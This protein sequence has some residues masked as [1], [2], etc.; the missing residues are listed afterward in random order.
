MTVPVTRVAVAAPNEASAQAGVR[1]AAEGGNAVDAALAATL[2]T[3]VNEIGVISPGSGGFVTVQPPGGD[4]VTI[5]G[6]VEMP[7]RGLPPER[8]GKG[9]WDITTE[10]GGGTT[11]TVG[12]GSVA[13]PGALKALDL[14]HERYG[15]APWHEV[16]Q[17]A[18]EVAR[19]GFPLSRT[20]AYYLGYTHEIIF[21][22]HAPSRAVVL[23][24]DGAVITAGS[25]VVIP[26]LAASLQLIADEGAAAVYTGDLAAM[27]ADDM[28]VGEGLLTRDDLAAYQAVVRPAL[29][30]EQNG[31]RLATNPPPA[32]GG[33]AVAAML[34]LLNG[35][36]AKGGWNA[37]EL[38]RLVDVQHAVLGRRLAELD[39]EDERLLAGRNLLELASSGDL[40]AL[41]SPSTATVS[42]VDDAGDA[43]AVTISSGYGSGTMTP[44]TGI[45]LNNALGEQELLAGG[46][47]SLAPG[48]RLTSNMAPTVARRDRDGAV[49]AIGSPGSDRI[50]TALAQVYAL[51]T[52]GGL[53]LHEAIEYPRLHVRVRDD[54]MVDYEED[55]RLPP[56]DLPSRPMPVHSMY[57]GGVA[58]AFW[59]PATGLTVAGDPRR[60]GATGLSP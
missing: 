53:P 52:H 20:S 34:A 33:V 46:V 4:P 47:H 25:T 21:G 31:W 58:A 24:G 48:T 45:W 37:E 11:T 16:V 43:C 8:F 10:Y 60:T 36:P 17:P 35:V 3:M 30:V 54:V 13:T 23:D 15:R 7:G 5:D 51:F 50:P 39:A 27:I 59:E 12:H 42:V 6:W 49:L 22:W 40:R 14:A 44:G 18:I 19:S 57:F 32:V 56:L 9:V 38:R 41:G 1:L 29:I 26:H 28:V 55:L 2:V